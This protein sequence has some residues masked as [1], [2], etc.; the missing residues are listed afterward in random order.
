MPQNNTLLRL[1]RLIRGSF[2]ALI[3]FLPISIALVGTFAAFAILF[4]LIKRTL[5][6]C[7]GPERGLRAF[8]EVI[9][10]PASFFN[11]PLGLFVAAVVVSVLFSQDHALSL[12]GFFGKILRGVFLY[13]SFLEAFREIRYLNNFIFVWVT[14]AF[15]TAVS[16][17]CQYF[18]G[19][20]FLRNTLMSR[21]RVSSSM[22]HANDFGAYIVAICPLLFVIL[23]H[24]KSLSAQLEDVP[25]GAIGSPSFVRAF[26]LIACAVLLVCLGLTFSR[27]AWLAFFAAIALTGFHKIKT[28]PVVF[29]VIAGFM[30]VFSPVMLKTRDASLIRDDVQHYRETVVESR[31]SE[32]KNTVV[33]SLQNMGGSGRSGFWK[34]AMRIIYD[35]PV[36]GSGLNTYSKVGQK[37]SFN[38]G[39]YPHNS[40][41]QMAAELGLLGL[42]AFLGML[43]VL[44]RTSLMCVN[45][46]PKGY[47]RSVLTGVLAGTCAYLIQ[48][49]FDTTFYSVQLSVLFWLMVS[50][51]VAIQRI[52]VS[53][54]NP[55]DKTLPLA[56]IG[57]IKKAACA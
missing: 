34:E 51:A 40:Y 36:W 47:L 21:E 8:F 56:R 5:V 13:S 43:F 32:Q 26:F 38:W 2:Y 7:A 3:F 41:L 10:P 29:V 15:V 37:Y 28:L 35:Y 31:S 18:H 19:F 33:Y 11:L 14:S 16:G 57:K 25:R 23:L 44:F 49:F 55:I 50:M 54:K 20:D 24:W 42:A 22:R 4:F 48:S 27:G 52:Q 30:M 45:R 12:R 39:G 53:S 1:D 17:L 46:M 6:V 9:R